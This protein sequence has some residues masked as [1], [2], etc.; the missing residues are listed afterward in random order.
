MRWFRKRKARVR[1]PALAHAEAQVTVS[2]AQA[3]HR[4]DT[5]QRKLT[6]ERRTVVQPLRDAH[7]ENHFAELAMRA[8]KRRST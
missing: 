3:F 8:M 1:D 2:Q 7:A 5:E 6:V 4:R